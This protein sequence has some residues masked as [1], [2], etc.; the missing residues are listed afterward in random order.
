MVMDI[1]AVR[2]AQAARSAVD[3]LDPLGL[4][5]GVERRRLLGA[6][7]TPEPLAD[8]LTR[9]A[10]APG[11]GTVLDPSFGGCAFLDAATS[12]LADQGVA[13]PNRLVYGV[14]VDPSCMDYVSASE[15]LLA[16]NCV[17]SDFFEL[18][19]GDLRGAPFRAVVGNPPFVRHHWFK[20]PTRHAAMRAAADAG[21][22]VPET[23]SAWAYFL[24]HAMRFIADGGRLTMLVPEALLQADYAVAIRD[25]VAA[26]FRSVRLIHLRD[27]LFDGTRESVVVV[28]AS[29]FGKRGSMSVESVQ[30]AD[31]LGRALRSPPSALN[32]PSVTAPNGRS[33]GRATIQLLAELERFGPIRKLADVAAVRIGLVTGA[34]SHFIR[35]REYLERIRVPR[36]AW[37]R[38]VPRTRWL[39]GLDFCRGDHERLD[40]AGRTAFLVRPSRAH[41][42]ASGVRQWVADGVAAGVHERSHCNKRDPWFRMALPPVPDA[43]GT[44][45]RMGSPLLVLNRAGVRCTNALH[46]IRWHRPNGTV[47]KAVCAGFLTSAVGAWAEYHGRRYGGGVLKLEPSILMRAPV[48]VVDAGAMAFDELNGL[49]QSG[50]EEEA[51]R[52]A[53]EVVLLDALG[54]SRK[55]VRG[56]QRA[57]SDLMH[58]R[59]PARNGDSGG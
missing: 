6:Y 58:Q 5:Q 52:L 28:A 31:D 8:T 25:A 30:H 16:E 13:N 15:S 4:V 43:F 27:R 46:E 59:R 55:D 42:K 18:M 14:D 32:S 51:R 38:I 17:V 36:R 20:G 23:A 49:M 9:W 10:L 45:T 40:R 50:R 2:S 39:S 3:N 56:L 41:E 29:G 24:V 34:N 47:P 44:C 12:V 11:A 22:S 48:P 54:L 35:S 7:Y 21:V 37:W 26:R 57:R 33:V 53:D 1:A 19:P